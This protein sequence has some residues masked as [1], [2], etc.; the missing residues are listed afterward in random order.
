M[1]LAILPYC[2]IIL[3]KKRKDFTILSHINKLTLDLSLLK[4]PLKWNNLQTLP[5]KYLV[6]RNNY[7]S[8]NLT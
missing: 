2:Y 8:Y 4:L 1:D 5:L 6:V 7:K 3:T